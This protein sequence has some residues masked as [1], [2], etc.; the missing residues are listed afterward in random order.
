MQSASLLQR[1]SRVWAAQRFVRAVKAA[2]SGD[3]EPVSE[4]L[5]RTQGRSQ[6]RRIKL[7]KEYEREKAVERAEIAAAAVANDDLFGA[8]LYVLVVRA[9]CMQVDPS[10]FIRFGSVRFGTPLW[11]L[12]NHVSLCSSQLVSTR[13]LRFLGLFLRLR[14]SRKL[15]RA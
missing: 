3:A 2:L 1:V 4:A 6:I 8:L 15:S 11:Q 14:F 12:E 9:S 10:V 7:A 13:F 5:K